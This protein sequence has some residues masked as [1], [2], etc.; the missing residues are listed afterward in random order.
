M[1]RSSITK[2]SGGT[3]SSPAELK[4]MRD[5]VNAKWAKEDTRIAAGFKD[6]GL[7]PDGTPTNGGGGGGLNAAAGALLSAGAAQVD[8]LVFARVAPGR[9]DWGRGD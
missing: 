4:A 2:D 6:V 5:A 7:N 3:M 8:T 9:E 1:P